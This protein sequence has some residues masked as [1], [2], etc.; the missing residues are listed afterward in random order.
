MK[1]LISE[2]M[3]LMNSTVKLTLYMIQVIID[4]PESLMT[5]TVSVTKEFQIG[6]GL[7]LALTNL[8]APAEDDNCDK[9]LSMDCFDEL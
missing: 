6:V 9:L 5:P 7:P 8:F 3:S 2:K 1:K 4:L